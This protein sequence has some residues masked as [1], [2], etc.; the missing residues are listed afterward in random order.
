MQKLANLCCEQNRYTEAEQL[1]T[2]ARDANKRMFGG[3]HPETLVIMHNMASMFKDQKRFAE[4]EQL[5][6]DTLERRR[7]TLGDEHEKTLSTMNQLGDLYNEM[8]R[9]QEAIQIFKPALEILTRVL[10]KEHHRTIYA[11]RKLGEAYLALER[12]EDAIHLFRELIAA[13]IKQAEQT[14]ATSAQLYDAAAMLAELAPL[15][16]QEPARALRY[17]KRACE[18]ADPA[19]PDY[20]KFLAALALTQHATGDAAAA[21]ETQKR[22]LQLMAADDTERPEAEKYLETYTSALEKTTETDSSQNDN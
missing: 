15:E 12:R 7:N 19:S 20:W 1:L 9:H 11:A 18:L 16:L 17:A 5:Y 4:A 21:V 3:D 14:D 6:L 8:N 13:M 10:G 2:Q 22:V